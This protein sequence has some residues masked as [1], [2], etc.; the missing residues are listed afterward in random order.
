[1][2][3]FLVHLYRTHRVASAA[4]YLAAIQRAHED[5]ALPAPTR[6]RFVRR[7]LMGVRRGQR[8]SDGFATP[9][10]AFAARLRRAPFRYCY[11]RWLVP[12]VPPYPTREFRA[13]VACALGA[14]FGLRAASLVALR[15]CDIVLG[16]RH[17]RV[18]LPRSKTD[19]LGRGA[20]IEADRVD[21]PGA[22]EWQRRLCISTLLRSYF[23]AFA[24]TGRETTPLFFRATTH[25]AERYVPFSAGSVTFWVRELIAAV[26]QAG[27]PA[28][29]HLDEE[30]HLSFSAHSLRYG[31]AVSLREADAPVD[32]IARAGRWAPRGYVPYVRGAHV[33]WRQ[34]GASVDEAHLSRLMLRLDDDACQ[35]PH[36]QD[37][38]LRRAPDLS[39]ST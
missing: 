1:M 23:D 31:L 6:D 36:E 30:D 10:Q 20:W 17:V 37:G 19:T 22:P 5:L 29:P 7:I 9:Q 32:V 3:L 26:R 35:G 18:F 38:V 14:R 11:L 33:P 34:W 24:L 16:H 12:L 8:L 28:P 15:P 27:P 2:A 21:S 4:S 25:A 13:L 39:T